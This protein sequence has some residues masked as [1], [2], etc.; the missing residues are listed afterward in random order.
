M[1]TH[2]IHP[3]E[4]HLKNLIICMNCWLYNFFP[5]PVAR[6]NLEAV[7]EYTLRLDGAMEF[8]L[9]ALSPFYWMHTIFSL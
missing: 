3:F 4:T 8:N 9:P 1:V 5:L 6:S 2:H 7:E